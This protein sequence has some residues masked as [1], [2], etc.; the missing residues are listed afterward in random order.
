MRYRWVLFCS[1]RWR[2]HQ[3]FERSNIGTILSGTYMQIVQIWH[4]WYQVLILKNSWMPSNAL[5]MTTHRRFLGS[6]DGQR[7]RE[8]YLAVRCYCAARENFVM[9]WL[10]HCAA[11]NYSQLL[12]LEY[13]PTASSGRTRLQ[14]L[15]CEQKQFQ[16]AKEI[17]QMER[18]YWMITSWWH[19][20]YL[21]CDAGQN[22]SIDW[23]NK[24]SEWW[25]GNK[26]KILLMCGQ[27]VTSTI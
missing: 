25:D 27:S 17:G 4:L 21:S 16:L 6:F 1:H 12:V 14:S 19:D 3:F 10:R 24:K 7:T 20:D 23:R 13:F 5:K 8:G 22:A 26:L 2:A 18:Y 15:V 9:E 11:V